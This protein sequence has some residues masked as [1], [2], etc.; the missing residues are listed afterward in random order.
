MAKETLH[1]IDPITKEYK[2]TK[3]ID[4]KFFGKN[5]PNTT[6][7]TLLAQK[8]GYVR[9]LDDSSF[10]QLL[11][12]S[13]Y[14]FNENTQMYERTHKDTFLVGFK[15][16]ALKE[17]ET[18]LAIPSDLES[19]KVWCFDKTSETW[20][21][22]SN[23]IGKTVYHTQTKEP[24]VVDYAG[25][26]KSDFTLLVPTEFDVWDGNAW[27]KDEQKLREK[28]I[29]DINSAC[30]AEIVSGFF[31]ETLGDKYFYY[32]TSEEQSN[33]N[34]LIMLGIDNQF[35]AQKVELID[36][37]EVLGTR[38]KYPHTLQQLKD[39]LA[40]GAI[41]RNEIIEKKD[42]LKEQLSIANTFE[43]IEAIGW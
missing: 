20:I 10:V 23:H 26:I 13:I 33:L 4:T 7:A 25:E 19:G 14:V 16:W 22:K 5:I 1:Y 30:D 24:F 43:E 18:L 21:A 11:I 3:E 17:N 8:E 12:P 42:N 41:K 39:V 6:K 34:S 2:Y 31:C 40:A 37:K 28:K 35:K 27:K 32:S 15:K 38:Q 36:G 29:S 9:I